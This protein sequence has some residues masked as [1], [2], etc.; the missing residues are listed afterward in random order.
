MKLSI[1]ILTKNES[2][3]IAEC[4][5]SIKDLADEVLVIDSN[6]IDDTANIARSLGAKVHTHEFKDFSN[7]RNY[8][9]SLAKGKWVLYLDAD[10]RATQSFKDEIQK[11]VNMTESKYP[12]YFIQRKT[13]Y[14]SQDWGLIDK[15]QRLFKKDK[16]IKWHGVV[17]ETPII[18]GEFGTVTHPVN[19]YTHRNLRQM[20]EKTNEWSEYEAKLRFESHHPKMNTVRFIRV[21]LTGFSNSY[22]KNRGYANGIAGIVE[23]IYQAFSMFITY[24]KL[25]EMQNKK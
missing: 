6:S 16:L 25:W 14:F 20:L 19:H 13:Y 18:E 4:L 8:A 23:S 15:V 3:C 2:D 17:H 9:V 10:E 1:L 24:A 11:I 5:K 22:F 7:Q 12:A 21:I